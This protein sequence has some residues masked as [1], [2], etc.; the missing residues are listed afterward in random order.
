M[1]TT[2]TKGLFPRSG[3]FI[4]SWEPHNLPHPSSIQAFFLI[5]HP[6]PDFILYPP[7]LR[8]Q[9]NNTTKPLGQTLSVKQA[10]TLPGMMPHTSN[11]G[12]GGRWLN[13]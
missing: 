2:H 4:S 11:H 6:S 8:F 10:L 7:E 9:P 5:T 12:G 3:S 13:L 1:H